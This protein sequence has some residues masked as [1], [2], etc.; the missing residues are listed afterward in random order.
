[1]SG[2]SSFIGLSLEE[3]RAALSACKGKRDEATIGLLIGALTSEHWQIKKEASDTLV[4]IGPSVAENL[5]STFK[6]GTDEQRSWVM[7][8]MARIKGSRVYSL[9]AEVVHLTGAHFSSVC[10]GS[11]QRDTRPRR[12]PIPSRCSRGRFLVESRRRCWLFGKARTRNPQVT[13]KGFHGG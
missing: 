2:L 1:M 8:I 6:N 13:P 7:K 4:S 5:T 9:A 3:A 12:C 11:S 10:L